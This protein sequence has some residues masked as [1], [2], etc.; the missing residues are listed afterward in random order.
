MAWIKQIEENEA[1]GKLKEVYEKILEKRGKLANIM[2][3]HSLDSESMQNHLDLYTSIMFNKSGLNREEKELVAVVV[4]ALNNCAYCI[5]HHAEALKH[6]WNDDEKISALIS[7]YKSLDFPIRIHAILNYAE[8]LTLTPSL[9]N[10]YDI[11]NLR[12]HN[13][14]DEDILNL[15]SVV[16]YFNFVNRIATGLGVDYNEEEIKGY[17]Y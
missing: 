2:K 17:K 3:I 7:D 1:E 14:T 10:E 8:K 12:I 9:V 16:S 6:Y 15:N 4:S 5:N 13:L 11:Q